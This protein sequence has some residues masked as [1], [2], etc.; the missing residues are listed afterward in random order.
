LLTL[1]ALLTATPSLPATDWFVDVNDANCAG[2][3]G[4]PTDPFCDIMLA[5][6]AASAGDTIFIAPGTYLEAVSLFK[7][8]ELIGTGGRLVTIVDGNDSARVMQIGPATVVSVQGLTLRNG[9]I[10]EFPGAGVLVESGATLSMSNSTIRGNYAESKYVYRYRCQGGRGGGLANEGGVVVLDHCSVRNNRGTQGGGIFNAGELTLTNTTVSGN[11]ASL[12]SAGY[13]GY[14]YGGGIYQDQGSLLVEDS[15]IKSGSADRGGGIAA[16]GGEVLLTRSIVSENRPSGIRTKGAGPFSMIDC[17]ITGNTNDG[18]NHLGGQAT[19]RR[20]TVS[21]NSRGI[22]TRTNTRV[23]IENTIIAG[24]FVDCQG[25]LDSLGHNLIGNTTSATIIGDPTGN[26]LNVDPLFVDL[27]NG[28]F[29]L[30]PG[31]PAIDA[32]DRSLPC[33]TDV[34]GNSRILDGN[35]DRRMALDIGAHEFSHARLQ[36][37]GVPAIGQTLTFEVSGTA[38]M[39]SF[40]FLGTNAGSALFDPFGC[41]FVD[42]SS[43]WGITFLGT[44][45][46]LHNELVPANGPSGLT[47]VFQAVVE[48]SG[49]G[50]VT[51][52]VELAF[53]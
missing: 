27:I 14:A 48:Q 41:L 4:G 47:L 23:D 46:V 33:T 20:C 10:K 15:V 8:L 24:Q 49:V 32:G 51:N 11:R 30:Q 9:Y 53:E 38:G 19:L 17:E 36:V 1:A 43:P 40:L 45:P 37:L 6:T 50:N 35:L 2:G 25:T 5:V 52:A 31:S 34:A 3:S 7:D 16:F 22:L 21:D 13:Y 29:A 42:L 28:D 44:T 12:C 39:N 26:L 18:L